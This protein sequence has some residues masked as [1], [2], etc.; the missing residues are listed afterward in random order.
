MF[1]MHGRRC[2]V[3]EQHKLISGRVLGPT[4]VLELSYFR[5]AELEFFAKL[6]TACKKISL[7]ARLSGAKIADADAGVSAAAQSG[8]NSPN[9]F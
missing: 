8:D 2:L 9:A 6:C 5:I 3:R 4:Q 7:D 1:P